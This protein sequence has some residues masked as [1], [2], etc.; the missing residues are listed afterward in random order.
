MGRRG[1]LGWARIKE[2]LKSDLIF[3]F[4]WSFRIWQDLK[5]IY[6]DFYEEFG[7]EDFSKFFLASKEFLENKICHAMNANLGQINL[8]KTF[9]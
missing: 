4:K 5:K 2:S 7:H 9:L 1:D 6:K 3:K 8:R